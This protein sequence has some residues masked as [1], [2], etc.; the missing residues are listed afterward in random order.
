MKMAM[1]GSGESVFHGG[2]MVRQLG[3]E[4]VPLVLTPSLL[5]SEHFGTRCPHHGSW[6]R[7]IEALIVCSRVMSAACCWFM[8][9]DKIMRLS[10][11]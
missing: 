3:W 9:A 10:S 1:C 2:V 6:M 5:V 7:R 4:P 11:I 8:F